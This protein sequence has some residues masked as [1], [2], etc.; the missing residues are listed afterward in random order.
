MEFLKQKL[1]SRK[2]WVSIAAAAICIVAAVMG[3][4]LTPEYVEILRYAVTACVA[5]IFGE[6]AVDVLRQIVEAVRAKY[7]IPGVDELLGDPDS[8]EKERTDADGEGE[9]KTA[10]EGEDKTA[11]EGETGGKA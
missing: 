7:E 11:G 9:G 8:G 10:G 6:S 2:L 3:E 1:G 5:Y 4:E